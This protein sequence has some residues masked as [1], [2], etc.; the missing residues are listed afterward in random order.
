MEIQDLKKYMIREASVYSD[1][2][3]RH[4]ENYKQLIKF[5]ENSIEASISNEG[6]NYPA[7]HRS[8][9]QSIRFLDTLIQSYESNLEKTR[10]LNSVIEKII[11]ENKPLGNEVV[12]Q[13]PM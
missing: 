12:Q 1:S 9:L 8:C 11:E 3:K 10:Y 13:D 5:F 6:V 4:V 2:D 7:L